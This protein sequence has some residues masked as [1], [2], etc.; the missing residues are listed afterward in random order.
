MSP[1]PRRLVVVVVEGLGRSAFALRHFG[2][3]RAPLTLP[4]PH[5]RL[6]AAA[7]LACGCDAT[8]H[9]VV[10]AGALEADGVRV[11]DVREADH[12]QPTF[13]R[14]ARDAGLV[15]H[16]IGWPGCAQEPDAPAAPSGRGWTVDRLAFDAATAFGA[17]WPLDPALAVPAAA[18]EAVLHQRLRPAALAVEQATLLRAFEAALARHMPSVDRHAVLPPALAWIAGWSGALA[19]AAA[20]LRGTPQ[21]ANGGEPD[22]P[23]STGLLTLYLSGLPEWLAALP[24]AGQPT[25]AGVPV[26]LSV[27]EHLLERLDACS[28]PRGTPPA[29]PAAHRL[30]IGLDAA[31]AGRGP[32]ARAALS[33]PASGAL[34]LQGPGV[35][36]GSLAPVSALE[37][38]GSVC[39]LLGVPQGSQAQAPTHPPQPPQPPQPPSQPPSQP[40]ARDGAAAVA[41]LASQG[42]PPAP[43]PVLEARA[44]RQ[45]AEAW[46]GAGSARSAHGDAAGAARLWALARDLTEDAAERAALSDLLVSPPGAA[47]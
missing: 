36:D 30:L 27:F 2:G 19:V 18:R 39:A 23:G 20:A 32:A 26:A 9:G 33:E 41:W 31:V 44:R 12:R 14:R 29:T 42:C 28:S 25:D 17:V 40:T 11:R 45:Q 46:A 8:E 35:A 3:A 22:A 16:V 24:A 6:P 7:T 47:P 21:P 4:A 5:G 15:A 13:W 43:A 37:V 1:L 10:T 38:A 34:V